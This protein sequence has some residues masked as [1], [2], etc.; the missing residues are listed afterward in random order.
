VAR[1]ESGSLRFRTFSSLRAN[2]RVAGNARRRVLENH[3]LI[4]SCGTP[5]ARFRS[6]T[7]PLSG[8]AHA[9]FNKNQRLNSDLAS[10]GSFLLPPPPRPL[11]FAFAFPWRLRARPE[12]FFLDVGAVVG[13]FGELAA[14]AVAASSPGTGTGSK[15][16]CVG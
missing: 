7:T 1:T 15:D 13:G 12:F 2:A 4:F 11:R 8:Y 3:V 6:F 5:V 16:T 9:Q 10:A 14:G